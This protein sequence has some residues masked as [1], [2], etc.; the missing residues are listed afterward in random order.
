[1]LRDTIAA[2][3]ACPD[4]SGVTIVGEARE[5]APITA[6]YGVTL[7]DEQRLRIPREHARDP[8]N[9]LLLAAARSIEREKAFFRG[10]TAIGIVHA[11][12]P[13]LT[14][15]ELA[16]AIDFMESTGRMTFVEDR[17]GEGTTAVFAPAAGALRPRFGTHSAARHRHSG[18]IATPGELTGLRCDVDTPADF[19]AIFA[20]GAGPYTRGVMSEMDCTDSFTCGTPKV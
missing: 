10:S 6:E 16:S 5:L 3:L 14:P 12:L 19:A 15:A 1:M 8:L 7:L 4:V 9:A 18:A 20:A 2:V 11:D 13:A 17:H